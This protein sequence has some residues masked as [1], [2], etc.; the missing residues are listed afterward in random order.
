YQV[1]GIK[2]NGQP[3]SVSNLQPTSWTVAGNPSGPG[4]VAIDPANTNRF[5]TSDGRRYFPVGQNVAWDINSTTN[6]VSILARLGA[7]REN[8]AR[9]WM[10]DWDGKNLDW[11][12]PSGNFGTLNLAVAQ[13]WDA[14][15][16]A[17]EQAGVFFQMTLQHHGQ[18][19]TTVDPEWSYNPYNTANG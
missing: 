6:V 8:W 17:A 3:I 15:V 13:K 2:L 14:I 16:S 12:R 7:A 5:I 11:P 1:A 10:D 18:Y 4:F 9:I 19:S